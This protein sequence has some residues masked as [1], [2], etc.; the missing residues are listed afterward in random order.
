MVKIPTFL[1]KKYTLKA[2]FFL[3]KIIFNDPGFLP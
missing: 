2:L 3:S 1:I